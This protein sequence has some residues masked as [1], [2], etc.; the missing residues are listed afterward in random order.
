[1]IR[2]SK[3]DLRTR[4]R[5]WKTRIPGTLLSW[6]LTRDIVETIPSQEVRLR[7]CPFEF[8]VQFIS[9]L[10]TQAGTKT[11]VSSMF[12]LIIYGDGNQ[13]TQPQPWS[14]EASRFLAHSCDVAKE[15]FKGSR[16]LSELDSIPTIVTGEW[17]GC[18][19]QIVR[20]G[21]VSNVKKSV[22][23][24]QF[25]FIEEAHASQEI[26]RSQTNQDILCSIRRTRTLGERV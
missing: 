25:N 22:G 13:W 2:Q 11:G 4:K 20:F 14:I 18:T 26:L 10:G 3:I 21:F 7:K 16:N 23:S 15:L 1:M 6:R 8:L 19:D 17:G 24:I 9:N 5:S 12:S